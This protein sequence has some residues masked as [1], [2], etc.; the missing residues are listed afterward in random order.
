[1]ALL[2]CRVWTVT[3]ALAYW[4]SIY[5]T[6]LKSFIVLVSVALDSKSFSNYFRLCPNWPRNNFINIFYNC[7]CMH[8]TV[9][10]AVHTG[11]CTL[12]NCAMVNNLDFDSKNELTWQSTTVITD[13]ILFVKYFRWCLVIWST[14][15]F[16]NN[17]V[18]LF[19]K[20][21]Y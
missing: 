4:T 20:R 12:F 9:I 8:C 2:S 15:S 18:N 19:I 5:G 6:T 13:V 3:N 1:M 10:S 11:Q 7:K 21:P 14:C 17:A 16:I